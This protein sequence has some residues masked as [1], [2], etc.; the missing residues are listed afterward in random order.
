MLCILAAPRLLCSMALLWYHLR[1]RGSDIH[2]HFL[3]VSPKNV[4]FIPFAHFLCTPLPRKINLFRRFRVEMC[5]IM[6]PILVNLSWV[7][8]LIE[9]NS[10]LEFGASEVVKTAQFW[11]MTRTKR[12]LPSLPGSPAPLYFTHPTPPPNPWCISFPGIPLLLPGVQKT[13]KN[14]RFCTHFCMSG[15]FRKQSGLKMAYHGAKGVFFR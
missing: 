10:K 11:G 1:T 2:L 9:K 13:C 3:F 7:P 6:A 8:G 5:I 15:H 12:L 14:L 4:I